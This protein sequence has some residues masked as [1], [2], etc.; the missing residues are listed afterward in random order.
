MKSI[1]FGEIKI[2]KTSM[3]M[4]EKWLQKLK[5]KFSMLILKIIQYV[6]VVVK[7][8]Y[9]F[10]HL[11]TLTEMVAKKEKESVQLDIT[12]TTISRKINFLKMAI[13]Y[14]VTTVISEKD[15]IKIV[16]IKK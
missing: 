1:K 3:N 8:I 16:H 15:F 10:F 9:D 14:Y 7:K 12:F 5:P 6:C 2:E 4:Q 13:R 11:I